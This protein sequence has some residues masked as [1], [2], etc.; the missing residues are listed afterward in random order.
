MK[1]FCDNVSPPIVEIL[2]T[3]LALICFS[4]IHLHVMR[5]RPIICQLIWLA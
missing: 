3:G 2:R 1:P 4:V 5:I